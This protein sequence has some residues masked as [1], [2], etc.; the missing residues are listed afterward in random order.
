M[1]FIAQALFSALRFDE[2]SARL[3]AFYGASSAEICSQTLVVPIWSIFSTVGSRR[4]AII[5]C[6]MVWWLAIRHMPILTKLRH[7]CKMEVDVDGP[8]RPRRLGY[9]LSGPKGSFPK[10][11][12]FFFGNRTCENNHLVMVAV[13]DHARSIIRFSIKK[14]PEGS[15]FTANNA[16]VTWL[17]WT[18]KFR[19]YR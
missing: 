17:D 7:F 18:P 6:H 13:T 1:I 19:G 9:S 14:Y 11:K 5:G 16:G 3:L 15:P 8:Q 4:S 2:L 12:K 10:K